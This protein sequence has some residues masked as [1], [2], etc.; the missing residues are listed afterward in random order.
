MPSPL[1]HINDVMDT[2]E[3]LNRWRRQQW[4]DPGYVQGVFDDL[5]FNACAGILQYPQLL[6]ECT[7]H[8]LAG[9]FPLYGAVYKALRLGL[10][11][12]MEVWEFTEEQGIHDPY[13]VA[14]LYTTWISRVMARVSIDRLKKIVAWQYCQE[15]AR[16]KTA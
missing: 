1:M 16:R 10:R 3:S 12:L 13:G 2:P 5:Q 15:K 11:G 6:P 14:C 8:I 9:D 7:A 4:R